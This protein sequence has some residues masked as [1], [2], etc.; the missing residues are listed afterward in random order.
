MLFSSIPFLYYFLPCVLLLYAIAPRKLK[1]SVLLFSSLFFY[2]WGEPK[3]LILMLISITQG[4]IFGRL[5]EKYRS[6][7]LAKLFLTLSVVF[8]FAMLGYCKYAD[9]FISGFNAVTGLSI[10]LLK[11]ALP[12]GISF[13]T[14][15]I[16]SYVIDVYRGDVAAQRN[17]INLAAYISMF[18]QL[19][20]GPIVRY[21]DIAAQLET[22][23]HS[24][25]KTAL[26][27]RRFVIGLSKKILLAN[28]L[29]ELVD[30]FK[31]T[32]DQSVLFYWL[33]AVAYTL[34]I[35]FDFSGYSDMAIG[36][37]HI[38]GFD[39]LENFNYPFISRSITEF[40]RR[41]HM[42]LGSWFRDY[43]YIPLGG[44]RVSAGRWIFNIAI[45]WAATGLWH[46]AAWNFV[47][48]GVYFAVL[49]VLEKLFLKKWLE[50]SPAR[51]HIYVMLLVIIS[52]VLFD[53]ATLRGAGETIGAMFGAGG[54][55]AA[56]FE[57]LYNLR[58][59]G[60]VLILGIIGST[61]LPKLAVERIRKTSGGSAL[62]NAVEPI[63]LI[64][65]LAVSTA[66]LIDGSFN[67]FLYFRF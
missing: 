18:P 63:V 6:K 1:N 55:P 33:Y 45:V 12:I 49:L 60:V 27:V 23:T 59:Y 41:W 19:I 20:A 32:N 48:W 65:L 8:S 5:V 46:G 24:T 61:P 3:Y 57:A 37:G 10:P 50:R 51:G 14:F 66:F 30:V 67:P 54:L 4:Y 15:Q 56:S 40:W 53:A 16:V 62:I 13:Y 26:G 44:N 58:S 29:G 38:F 2:G 21:A 43:L 11:I 31:N 39:F 35:Y 34:H 28:V 52:F 36:L 47:A 22:R 7:G 25:A 9:F 64:A 42:S 17:Y